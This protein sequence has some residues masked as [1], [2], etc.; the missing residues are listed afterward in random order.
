MDAVQRVIDWG[1]ERYRGF[2]VRDVGIFKTC[3]LSIGALL[4][5]YFGKPLK[6]LAPVLWVVA[7][8][9]RSSIS[10]RLNAGSRTA[11]GRAAARA[12]SPPR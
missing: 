9:A 2:S 4:G 5:V 8:T 10:I 11:T 3:L 7:P 6:K 12:G 1:M